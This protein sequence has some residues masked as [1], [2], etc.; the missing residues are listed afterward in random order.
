MPL[1]TVQLVKSIATDTGLSQKKSSEILKTLLNSLTDTLSNGGSVRIRGFGKLFLEHRKE[2][3]IRHPSTGQ[4]IVIG[5]QKTVKFKC[6]KSLH[7][8][9]NCY[10]LDEFKRENEFILQRLYDLLENSWEYE[11]G[12]DTI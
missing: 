8:E 1:T 6:F 2:R 10:D 5:P 4:S 9:I 11:E 7:Q 12:E 3:K